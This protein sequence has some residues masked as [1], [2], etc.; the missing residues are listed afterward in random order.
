MKNYEKVAELQKKIGKENTEKAIKAI[1]Y[2]YENNKLIAVK[3]LMQ[4]TGLSRSY[5]Y[6]N[7][8]VNSIL[9][10]ILQKQKGEDDMYSKTEV[11][12]IAVFKSNELLER[13]IDTL[14]KRCDRLRRENKRLKE[15][16]KSLEN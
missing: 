2:L 14:E 11:F 5:F 16:I 7:A 1:Y 4:L 12:N 3:E 15:K 8:K 10:K 6:K 9:K 13:Q